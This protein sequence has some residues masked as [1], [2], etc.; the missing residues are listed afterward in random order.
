MCN[1]RTVN[2]STSVRPG[3]ACT[4]DGLRE[5][6]GFTPTE[7]Q[8]EQLSLKELRTSAV[9]EN[10]DRY[11]DDITYYLR[12][13]NADL[14]EFKTIYPDIERYLAEDCYVP[15]EVRD[16]RTGISCIQVPANTMVAE[17]V[18]TDKM[19]AVVVPDSRIVVFM[20]YDNDDGDNPDMHVLNM[21]YF[22]A[23]DNNIEFAKK[24]AR[25][26]AV[27]GVDH[28]D[29]F[30]PEKDARQFAQLMSLC[31]GLVICD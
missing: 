23:T 6:I 20:W 4:G 14:V 8:C 21:Q 12:Q 25:G 27:R 10:E 24:Y 19:A 5:L 17:I 30:D 13:T 1:E 18:K 16:S 31:N 11:I 26:T 28:I 9:K 15:N 22:D 29:A 7:E 3:V 2:F